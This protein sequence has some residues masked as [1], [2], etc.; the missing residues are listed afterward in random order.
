MAK[1]RVLLITAP[2][3]VAFLASCST[4]NPTSS[5]SDPTEGGTAASSAP[6]VA[7]PDSGSQEVDAYCDAVRELVQMG[8]DAQKVMSKS[9]EV[10]ALGQEIIDSGVLLDDPALSDQFNECIESGLAAN[11]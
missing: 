5:S 3:L 8:N 6:S 10:M 9:Q 7:A 1:F 2:L 11:R 4:A